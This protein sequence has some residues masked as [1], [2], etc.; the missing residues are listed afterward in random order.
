VRTKRVAEDPGFRDADE[1]REVLD[2]TLEWLS[3][4][5]AIG[6]ALRDADVP[7]RF[8]V[9]DL[10]L[11]FHIRAARMGETGEGHLRWVWHDDVEWEPA[12]TFAM[13]SCVF[14]RF[15]QGRENVAIGMARRRIRTSGDRRGALAVL[16]LLKPVFPRYRAMLEADFPHLVV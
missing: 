5:D 9:T 16:P 13:S 1:F 10:G 6:G 7:E 2:R 12:V 8:E 15:F 11:V 14:N 3:H 4:D